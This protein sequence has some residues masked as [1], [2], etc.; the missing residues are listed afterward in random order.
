MGKRGNGEGEIYPAQ[1]R[2]LMARYTVQTA[3]GRS[4]IP[5]TARSGKTSRR[6]WRRRSPT[7]TTASSSTRGPDRRA[8]TWSGGLRTPSGAASGAAPTSPIGVRCERY[9]SRPSGA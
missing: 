7:V 1:G 2:A 4:A 6:S 8:S 9:M 5:S 3:T